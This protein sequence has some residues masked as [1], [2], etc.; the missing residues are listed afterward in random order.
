VLLPQRLQKPQRWTDRREYILCNIAV[1][2]SDRWNKSSLIKM[3]LIVVTRIFH[4]KSSPLFSTAE[5]ESVVFSCVL[6]MSIFLV[7]FSLMVHFNAVHRVFSDQTVL[8]TRKSKFRIFTA[9]KAPQKSTW[10][11]RSIMYLWK[12]TVHEASYNKYEKKDCVCL[13]IF[14][15][16]CI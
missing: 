5:I 15:P 13:C 7:T 2:I 11:N 12:L 10:Y 9:M 3:M 6:V 8:H 14:G 1:D 16:E 4:H